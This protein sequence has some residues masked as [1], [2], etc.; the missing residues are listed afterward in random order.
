MTL[1]GHLLLHVPGDL[2]VMLQSSGSNIVYF[3]NTKFYAGVNA[4]MIYTP[5]LHIG[6]IHSVWSSVDKLR[7]VL[8]LTQKEKSAF[9]ELIQ[10]E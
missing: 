5:V 2:L 10:I 6:E 1:N 8:S 7:P 4:T 9:C 3:R